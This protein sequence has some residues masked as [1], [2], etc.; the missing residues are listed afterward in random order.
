M[1]AELA[2]VATLAAS[3]AALVACGAAHRGGPEGPPLHVD[4]ARDARGKQLFQRFCF[5]CHPNGGA[6]L[7]PALNNKPLPEV[8][9]RTQIHKGVG[10]MPSFDHILRDDEVA[11]IAAYVH[12]LRDMPST[13]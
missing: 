10:A 4:S 12:A 13:R 8:A 6:G 2:L 11:A 9:V 3:G 1:R 5:Q 7:G